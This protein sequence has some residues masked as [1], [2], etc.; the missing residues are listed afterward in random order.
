L[1]NGSAD[2]GKRALELLHQA[3]EQGRPYD[4]AI[5][6]MQMPEM[7][8]VQLAAE[9]KADPTLAHT[10]LILL[11]SL[12]HRKSTTLQEAGFSAGL[13]KPVRQSQL[14]D[15]IAN[16]MRDTLDDVAGKPPSVSG[17]TSI[18]AHG[19]TAAI[20]PLEP[21]MKPKLILVVEDNV[22][23]EGGCARVGEVRLL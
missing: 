17:D 9:I 8:G 18:L 2:N 20:P 13:T 11:T 14:F 5:L 16:V 4:L 23:P 6:D 1:S 21:S 19:T 22:E 10:R 15:C 3:V 7:D 12:G